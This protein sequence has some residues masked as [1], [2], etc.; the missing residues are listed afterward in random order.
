L[1]DR[2][3]AGAGSIEKGAPEWPLSSALNETF[4]LQR[5]ASGAD[6]PIAQ[7]LQHLLELQRIRGAVLD[8]QD[9]P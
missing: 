7:I 3:Q 4:R 6:Y 5:A 1:A 2:S 8:H 9:T